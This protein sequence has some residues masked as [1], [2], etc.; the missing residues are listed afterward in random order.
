M[1]PP[2]NMLLGQLAKEEGFSVGTLAKWRAEARAKGQFPPLSGVLP[3][4]FRS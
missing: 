2:N 3:P 4:G 1:L